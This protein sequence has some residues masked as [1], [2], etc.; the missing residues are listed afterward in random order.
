MVTPRPAAIK[1]QGT[2]LSRAAVRLL[3]RGEA[4]G[5]NALSRSFRKRR[6]E[7]ATCG[8]N[9]RVCRVE[10]HLDEGLL[11]PRTTQGFRYA[12]PSTVCPKTV[13]PD[14]NCAESF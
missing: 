7:C 8:A 12:W 3:D 11:G 14:L 9:T 10:T 2:H 1:G 5:K 6:H 4:H 13:M